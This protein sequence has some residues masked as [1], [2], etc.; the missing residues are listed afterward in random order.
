VEERDISLGFSITYTLAK[1]GQSISR[2]LV[3]E[4]KVKVGLF[5]TETVGGVSLRLAAY[6][7]PGLL[8]LM[9]LRAGSFP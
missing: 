9:I 6:V 8:F 1:D 3:A 7:V 5:G 4:K 2:Y